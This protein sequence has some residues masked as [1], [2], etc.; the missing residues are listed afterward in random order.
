MAA[1]DSTRRTHDTTE[2]KLAWLAELNESAL[3]AGAE[4]AVERQRE[5]GKLLARE[6]IDKLVDP[7]S[8]VELG[9][10]VGAVHRG[11]TPPAPADGL[12][13]G[14]ARIDG[15]TV[16]VGSE[17]FTVMGG[18]I[19]IGTHAKRLRLAKLAGQEGVPLVMLLEGAGERSQNARADGPIADGP[20]GVLLWLR[21][22]VHRLL[23]G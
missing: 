3:H 7:G 10:L 6:R 18:S 17:D 9:A 5:R 23:I 13:G 20:I 2:A 11:V 16:V 19:G 12:V 1:D 14:H 15:R 21:R 8:F 4:K 22:D